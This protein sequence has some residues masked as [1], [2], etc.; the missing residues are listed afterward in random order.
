MGVSKEEWRSLLFS[1]FCEGLGYT[2]LHVCILKM[3]FFIES[4]RVCNLHN[5]VG[6]D[7][8]RAITLETRACVVDQ[9]PFF[10][11]THKTDE[12]FV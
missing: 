1:L 11:A 9:S 6:R 4:K 3:S 10:L 12:N 2:D 7:V 5:L 8:N